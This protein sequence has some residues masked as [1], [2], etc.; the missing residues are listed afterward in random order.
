MAQRES[1]EGVPHLHLLCDR[2]H[3][4]EAVTEAENTGEPVLFLVLVGDEDQAHDLLVMRLRRFELR[5]PSRDVERK[6]YYRTFAMPDAFESP[7]Q[8]RDA[9]EDKGRGREFPRG[10]MLPLTR[11]SE[12]IHNKGDVVLISTEMHYGDW[13]VRGPDKVVSFLEFFR[14]S[15][16]SPSVGRRLV[17]CLNIRFDRDTWSDWWD[18]LFL[19]RRIRRELKDLGRRRPDLLKDRQVFVIEGVNRDHARDWRLLEE[20]QAALPALRLD[21]G[22]LEEELKRL[23]RLSC[24]RFAR[25][26]AMRRFARNLQKLLVERV[27]DNRHTRSPA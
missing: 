22:E 16:P 5:A 26:A 24:G 27:R 3:P 20:V 7:E 9:L 1:R 17:V 12:L 11:V 13:K 18:H 2:E 15:W 19:S 21:E 6:V 10:P 25:L 4:V 23:H 8:F 14:R